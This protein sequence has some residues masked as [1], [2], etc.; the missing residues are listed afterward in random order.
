MNGRES[1]LVAFSAAL[2]AADPEQ[3]VRKHLTV[4][5]SGRPTWCIAVGKAAAPM[6]SGAIA[7][8]G[9][10]I[11][12][13]FLITKDDHIDRHFDDRFILREASHPVLDQRALAATAELLDW[14]Q[15]IPGDERVLVLLSGGGSALLERPVDE[16]SL[17]EFQ[18]MT[19][20]LLNAGA[21]IYQLNCVRSQVSR[22]KGGRLRAAIPAAIVETLA[23]SDVLGNDP[24]VIASGP[25]ARTSRGH[26]DALAVLDE[27]AVRDQMPDSVLTVLNGPERIGTQSS[28][29]DV[30]TVI[31][32]N[33]IGIDA[34]A[35]SLRQSGGNVRMQDQITNGEA[36]EVARQWVAGLPDLGTDVDS[37]ISG[38]ELTVTVRGEGLGGRNTEF[39]LAAAIA[40]KEQQIGDWTIASLATDGQDALSGFAG[41]IVDG[42]TA[43]SL[44]AAGI[45]PVAALE[46]N[47]SATA[48]HAVGA[49]VHTGPTGTNVNDLYFAVRTR[50]D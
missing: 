23:L 6:L 40:M 44:V 21:D 4:E 49:T 8:L 3:A 12:G 32:D 11:R 36:R 35:S 24:T 2:E 17:A 7:T 33:R 50:A 46:A 16:V 47:D 22:V 34:A 39:A 19:S 43:D 28:E 13:G 18:T 25:T 14:I 20:V 9:D 27:L 41:A 31:A 5:P 1:I 26:A 15:Q 45:D 10:S 30:F 38:G 48:L 29:S 42:R 37:V